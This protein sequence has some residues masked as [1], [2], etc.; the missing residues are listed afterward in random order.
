[1]KEKLIAIA[2]NIC[3]TRFMDYPD[4]D[5]DIELGLADAITIL[6]S[7][8]ISHDEDFDTAEL[9]DFIN[10]KLKPNIA[11]GKYRQ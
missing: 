10:Q 7:E 5:R 2:H 9:Y 8:N 1:M 6:I 3:K 11:K 4:Y